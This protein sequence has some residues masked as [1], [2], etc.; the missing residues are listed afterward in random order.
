MMNGIGFIPKQAVWANI[1]PAFFKQTYF[2]ILFVNKI[3]VL[4]LYT[5]LNTVLCKCYKIFFKS[6]NEWTCKINLG[7]EFIQ[8][9]RKNTFKQKGQTN[10]WGRYAFHLLML[11]VWQHTMW[12]TSYLITIE[13]TQAR[14]QEDSTM[15]DS[16]FDGS[17]EIIELYANIIHVYIQDITFYSNNNFFFTHIF[18]S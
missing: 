1:R 7:T 18:S 6:V 17:H 16:A 11:H 14:W 13:W 10:H 2:T 5:V 12:Y 8:Y 4:L 15:L 3:H 9:E